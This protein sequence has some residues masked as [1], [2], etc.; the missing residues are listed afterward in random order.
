MIAVLEAHVDSIDLLGGGQ[1][2]IQRL[3]ALLRPIEGRVGGHHRGEQPQGA[4]H[5]MEEILRTVHGRRSGLGHLLMEGRGDH[6]G[7]LVVVVDEEED[8]DRDAERHEQDSHDRAQFRRGE[9]AVE[10]LESTE[11]P[12]SYPTHDVCRL[13]SSGENVCA[14]ADAARVKPSAAIAVFM[15][16]CLRAHVSSAP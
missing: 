8:E 2:A 9:R 14:H 11:S 4:R 13:R 1:R 3:P 5:R 16:S 12:R 6:G 10:K 7:H 15:S